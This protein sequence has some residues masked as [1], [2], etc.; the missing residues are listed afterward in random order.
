MLPTDT[1]PDRPVSPSVRFLKETGQDGRGQSGQT[2]RKPDSKPDKP[3]AHADRLDRI[4]DRLPGAW[5]LGLDLDEPDEQPD[6]RDDADDGIEMFDDPPP[7]A[8]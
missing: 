4:R 3:D 8:A 7:D 6:E 1:S 5:R 2:G